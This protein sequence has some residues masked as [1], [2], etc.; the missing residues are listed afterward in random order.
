[1]LKRRSWAVGLILVAVGA[2]LLLISS[3]A[4]IPAL[5]ALYGTS[6]FVYPR[7]SRQQ[8]Y[9]PCR[10]EAEPGLVPGYD[11]A[12]S[13]ASPGL[14]RPRMLA[15]ERTLQEAG[16]HD[17]RL[18]GLL[19]LAMARKGGF[20]ATARGLEA[21]ARSADDAGLW[22]DASAAFY[23]AATAEDLPGLLSPALAASER[24]LELD[25][26]NPAAAFNRALIL[27]ALALRSE[28][29]E[30]WQDFLSFEP[31]T[32][33]WR[34]EAQQHLETL[35]A[36]S[37]AERWKAARRKIEASGPSAGQAG[38]LVASFARPVRDWIEL[39]LLPAWAQAWLRKDPAAAGEHLDVAA[40][41]ANALAAG[42][43]EALP[44]AQVRDVREVLQA[45]SATAPALA[46]AILG[47][48][49]ARA[50]YVQGDYQSTLDTLDRVER[51]LGTGRPALR[52]W[53]RYYRAA[54]LDQQG[55]KPAADELLSALVA[56]LESM[57]FPSLRARAQA[58]R[59][60]IQNNLGRPEEAIPLLTSAITT[61]DAVR[62]AETGTWARTL[63]GDSHRLLGDLESCWR[64][65]YVALHQI[66]NLGTPLR[67]L[68]AFNAMAD[69]LL[70]ASDER[71]AL[72]Y[73]DAAVS[74]GPR[75]ENPSFF[76]EVLLWRSLLRSRRGDEP[77]ALADLERAREEAAKVRDPLRVERFRA[78][79]GLYMGAELLDRDPA[80][81]VDALTTAVRYF[82]G[83]EHWSRILLSLEARALAYGRLGDWE[84]ELRDLARAR[85][86]YERVG[87]QLKQD[88]IRI[89][90]AGR[91]ENAFDQ[92]LRLRLAESADPEAS[93]SQLEQERALNHPL[94]QGDA[95]LTK[96]AAISEV[97][98]ALAPGMA[99]VEYAVL[100]DR[101]LVW[102]VASG[103]V[104]LR[105]SAVPRA[106]LSAAVEDF[107]VADWSGPKWRDAS[108]FLGKI[109]LGAVQPELARAGITS[110]IVVPDDELFG[111]PFAA[112]TLPGTDQLLVEDYAVAVSPSASLFARAVR[113]HREDRRGREPLRAVA[114]ADPAIDESIWPH[115]LP[116]DAAAAEGASLQ[117]LLPGRAELLDGG[118]ATAPALRGRLAHASWLHFAGHAV[119]VPRRPLDSYL[120]LGPSPE[121]SG[122]LTAAELLTW[123]LSRLRGVVLSA[124]G[125][126]A[127][128][129]E[130]WPGATTLARP[131]LAAGVPLVIGSLWDVRDQDSAAFFD[132]FYRQL[133]LHGSAFQA[134]HEAQLTALNDSNGKGLSKNGWVAFQLYG[135]PDAPVLRQGG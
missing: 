110:L 37:E 41:L 87:R 125:S 133:A 90:F 49:D 114:V 113:K 126:A 120:L 14:L 112:L 45:Q 103:K 96:P 78:D 109:L 31:E 92:T 93:F 75:L 56:D 63:L 16:E 48:Q 97:R 131:F 11:C 33:P 7:L 51:E 123:D 35:S 59:G 40:A 52:Y 132:A 39:E 61:L 47:L 121:H 22:V 95:W 26:R 32:S 130:S 6:R 8:A 5:E 107:L 85:E 29:R 55:L 101:L 58:L 74:L 43:R 127:S 66:E 30:A 65:Y 67:E 70:S 89:S 68:A 76:A 128:A 34:R 38:E 105:Q 17:R 98:S 15:A 134:F 3:R 25:P 23:L 69:F 18:Y 46:H 88:A 79:L 27:E 81:A 12:E 135:G 19:R 86:L 24:A 1:M 129:R 13:P 119:A 72:H 100:S 73:L 84:S 102:L 2:A 36:P 62:D 21:E 117:R 124:C 83:T 64:H 80:A 111:L 53:A 106:E 104:A 9:Q 94:L 10:P 50:S 118:D 20:V 115:L 28:A 99:L 91:I 42:P 77:A 82:E 57:P 71:L 122:R 44:A 60:R 116:L 4:G 54:S 108:A